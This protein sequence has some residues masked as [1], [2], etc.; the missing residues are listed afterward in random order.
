LSLRE[1]GYRIGLLSNTWWAADWHNADL[2]EHGLQDLLDAVVYT[3]DMPHSKPHPSVFH[4]IASRLGVDAERCLMVGD[5]P[6]D[7]I[8]GALGAGMLAVFKTNG[9]PRPIPNGVHPTATIETLAELPS[10]LERLSSR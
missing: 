5:R 10:L 8:R 7:D 6:V 4:E 9:H 3:S 1:Q 2:A